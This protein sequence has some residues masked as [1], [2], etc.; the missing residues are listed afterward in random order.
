VGAIVT[1]RTIEKSHPIALSGGFLLDKHES[2]Q[3]GE[4]LLLGSLLGGGG[5]KIEK[6]IYQIPHLPFR[7]I[8]VRKLVR[9]C[10]FFKFTKKNSQTSGFYNLLLV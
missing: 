9:R 7:V 3:L 1:F 2:P 4:M 8:L 5:V 10:K 6:F